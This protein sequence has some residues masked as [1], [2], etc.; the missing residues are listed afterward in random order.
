MKLGM[1]CF[2]GLGGSGVVATELAAGLASR[3]HEVHLLASARPAR[4][5]NGGMVFHAVDVPDYPV[6]EHAPYDLAVAGAIARLVEE[7]RLDLVQ[8]HYAVP[9][10][11]SALLARQLLGAA[12]PVFV[13]ALHGTDVTRLA[14]AY[15]AIT[16]HAVAAADG[17]TAPSDFLRREATARLAIPADRIA[18]LPNFVD[19]HRFRAVPH[20]ERGRLH[21]LFPDRGDGPILFHVSNFR[22]VKRVVDLLE[23]L[24]RVREQTPA[25][26]VLVGD[27]PERHAV[28]ERATALGLADDVVF[29]GRRTD[30]ADLLA[31]ADAFV[32]PS[33]SESFGVA[34]LEALASGVPVCAYRV[35]GLPELVHEHVGRLVP[36]G[37]VDAL[38]GA[39]LDV[40]AH[41][42]LGRA[43]RQHVLDHF[44]RDP[45]LDHYE[46]YFRELLGAAR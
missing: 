4:S 11:V 36:L 5:Q 15:Q 29:L 8:V 27:G 45:A 17:I 40:I 9:H 12:A 32:L 44:Q 21:A 1:V 10:A 26:L 18:V 33:E 25:R 2:S 16:A 39:V 37:Q 13:T 41:P 23:V 14:P 22:A 46:R 34:A 7:H 42:E 19:A 35:G 28:A 31:H 6:F 20:K 30:F 24:V 43:A 3:G 38:A